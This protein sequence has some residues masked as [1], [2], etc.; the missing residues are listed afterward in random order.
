MFIAPIAVAF[1][2]RVRVSEG[3]QATRC[4]AQT[5]P[6]YYMTFTVQS[7]GINTS[8]ASSSFSRSKIRGD[9]S[10]TINTRIISQCY[11][12]QRC[13]IIK[14]RY[15]FL[16]FPET[17]RVASPITGHTFTGRNCLENIFSILSST[18]SDIHTP[19]RH[20][21]SRIARTK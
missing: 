5:H 9:V 11:S 16:L 18:F 1:S 2:T 10:E 21:P 12:T 3:M 17:N 14:R 8:G 6:P 15:E 13:P 19:R 7:R 20:V 4:S